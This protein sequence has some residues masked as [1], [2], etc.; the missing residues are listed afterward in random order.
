MKNIDIYTNTALNTG[1]D[2]IGGMT[3]RRAANVIFNS[4][5]LAENPDESTYKV[6]ARVLK[7]FLSN[8]SENEGKNLRGLLRYY[9]LDD[10][11]FTKRYSGILMTSKSNGKI[12]T[13]EDLTTDIMAN[14]MYEKAVANGRVR[15]NKQTPRK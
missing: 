2:R 5:M 4:V 1:I 12:N 15:L 3:V 8:I 7:R 14:I 10:T 9:A 13:S 11:E 6:G